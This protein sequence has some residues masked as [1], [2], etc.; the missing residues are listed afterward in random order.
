MR[1]RTV[2]AI[3]LLL[4]AGGCRRKLPDSTSVLMPQ[5]QSL[6]VTD[7]TEYGAT[8]IASVTRADQ[9]VRYGFTVEKEGST[10]SRNVSATLDG[11]LITV[12]L[13]DLDGACS[14]SFKAYIDN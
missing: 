11:N 3:L 1:F 10:I 12:T 5:I 4:L 2:T 8:L 13:N 9:L 14:Y 7:I 6:T